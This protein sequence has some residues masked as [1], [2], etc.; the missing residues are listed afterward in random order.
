[1]S[2]SSAHFNFDQKVAH[3]LDLHEQAH[4]QKSLDHQTQFPYEDHYI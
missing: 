4:E 3:S 1:M 2:G